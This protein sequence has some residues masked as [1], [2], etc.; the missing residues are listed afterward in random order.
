[1]LVTPLS[2]PLALF[3][4]ASAQ[5]LT[6]WATVA[7]LPAPWQSVELDIRDSGSDPAA[8][9]QAALVTQPDVVFGPYG[10]SPMLTVARASDRVVWNHGGASASLT[11]QAFPGIIN[12]ISPATA[13]FKGVLQAT[14]AYD[15]RASSVSCFHTTT[16]FGRDIAAGVQATASELNF[17]VQFVPFDPSQAAALVERVPD[18][19]ILLVAGN[20]ADE[21][22]V[23]PILLNRSW[24]AS[25]FVGAGVDEVLADLGA[26]RE[27]LLGPAQ[28]LATVPVQ[29]DEGPDAFWFVANYQQRFGSEP[30]YP[31]AQSFAAGLLLARCLRTNGGDVSAEAQLATARQLACTTLYGVF[32]LDPDD[33]LQV[34]HQV[35]LVQWQ[36][37]VRRVVWP[38]EYAERPFYY[39]RP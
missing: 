22:A 6:L 2:G 1:M 32:R 36:Q 29:P 3:G 11:R 23:A 35:L 20:F 33:G 5:G 10:S 34:G 31:A 8:A 28:W 16:G 12:V 39:P 24:R 21:Q 25:A 19:D 30:P 38:P 18:A 13:Y 7:E 26:R 14:R 27:G 4:R 9:L 17:A 37:G 15:P